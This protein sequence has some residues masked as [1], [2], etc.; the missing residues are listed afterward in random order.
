[1]ERQANPRQRLLAQ[2]M[3]DA[4]A[5]AVIGGHPHNTAGQS[6]HGWIA[7]SGC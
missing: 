2:R 1:N 7:D 4:G 5:D 6:Q 3:V